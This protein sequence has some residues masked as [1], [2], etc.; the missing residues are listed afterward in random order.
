MEA[1]FR[2]Y[3]KRP[4]GGPMSQ[5]PME[6]AASGA[7]LPGDEPPLPNMRADFPLIAPKICPSSA[8]LPIFLSLLTAKLTAN[9]IDFH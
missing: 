7:T 8:K 5:G 2:S 1:A 9:A 6:K 4:Y 3:G